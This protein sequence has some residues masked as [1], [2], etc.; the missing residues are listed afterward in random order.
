M[1]KNRKASS[2]RRRRGRPRTDLP[3][4][5]R[6]ILE[7]TEVPP[8]VASRPLAHFEKHATAIEG[9]LKYVDDHLTAQPIYES[10]FDRHMTRLR[11]MAF[12]AVVEAFER[13]LNELA[14][15]CV[16]RLAPYIN[17]GRFDDFS[18]TGGEISSCFAS[19]SIGQALC[20]SKTWLD[21][22]TISGRFRKLL[23]DP[24]S[25][26]DGYWNMFLLP[27]GN[28]GASEERK[29]AE[30][31]AVL[32][33]IRHTIVHNTGLLTASDSLKLGLLLRSAVP[34]NKVLAPSLADF[35]Y[36]KRF[37]SVKADHFNRL[38]GERLAETVTVIH[39]LSPTL[40]DASKEAALLSESFGLPLKV[41]GQVGP[42]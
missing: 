1:G 41:E 35:R 38:I 21:N 40:I 28:Q 22:Q 26:N 9:L 12:V 34:S 36:A 13:F 11:R 2:A 33:R 14:I 17:D 31:V 37:L 23:K 27:R 25:E 5:I 29:D 24:F 8:A 32:W 10:V 7:H 19:G 6:G 4:K 20:D 42:P 15:V 3:S 30:A 18:A 39:N 16:D